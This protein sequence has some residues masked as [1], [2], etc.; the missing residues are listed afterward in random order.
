MS[1]TAIA[2]KRRR[3]G[4]ILDNGLPLLLVGIFSFI[5]FFEVFVRA[6]EK[7]FWYDELLTVYFSRLNFYSLWS[8]LNSGVDFNPPLFYLLTRGVERVFGE[9]SI[10]TRLPEMFGF[11]VFCVCLFRFVSLR[12]GYLA[13]TVAMVLPLFTGAFYYAYEA[14][15]HG[16]VLGCCGL[17]LVCWQNKWLVGFSLSLLAGFMLHCYAL[18]LVVPFACAEVLQ[19]SRCWRWPFWAALFLPV[20]PATVLY[21]PLLISFQKITKGTPFTQWFPANWSQVQNFYSFLLGPAILVVLVV[22]ILILSDRVRSGAWL[23]SSFQAN[24]PSG[25][26][27]LAIS[28]LFMPVFGVILAKVVHGPFFARYFQ[29]ALAGVCMLSGFGLA[30]GRTKA[31]VT[32][33]TTFFVIGMLILDAGR[34]AWHWHNGWVEYLTEPSTGLVVSGS[35]GNPLSTDPLLADQQNGDLPIDILDPLQYLYY[36]HYAPNLSKRL[37]CALPSRDDISYRVLQSL[38]QS[39][40][41][42]LNRELTYS[43]FRE[44]HSDFLVYGDFRVLDQ[45]RLL[46]GK[47]QEKSPLVV[48]GSHF[49][50]EVTMSNASR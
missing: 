19:H 7:L 50:T 30:S 33:T 34:L 18:L 45:L 9:G 37:F 39:C 2:A 15:P 20:L 3:A 48:S 36:V 12:S 29:S 26:L 21:I 44:A 47:G 10:G 31:W 27:I 43:E 25:E 13:G 14:R 6:S 41:I 8:A 22:F 24:V 38:R 32:K 42:T 11:W 17:A 46:V 1:E 49:M 40:G 4:S 5:Y 35:P 28:F 23:E 16:I